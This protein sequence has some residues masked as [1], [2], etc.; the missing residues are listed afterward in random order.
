M[1]DF[2]KDS[3]GPNVPKLHQFFD[4]Y[5][6]GEIVKIPL[7]NREE[8]DTLFWSVTPNGK[9]SIKTSCMMDRSARFFVINNFPN[10]LVL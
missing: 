9:F 8:E 6:I 5:S 2:I 7:L 3:G 4:S 1:K 10:K